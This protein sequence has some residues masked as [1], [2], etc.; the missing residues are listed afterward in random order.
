MS[1]Q[2]EIA[3]HYNSLDKQDRRSDLVFAYNEPIWES[4]YRH[5]A[6]V[7]AAEEHIKILEGRKNSEH[8]IGMLMNRV[9]YHENKIEKL[10]TD[11][12][13]D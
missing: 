2:Q 12:L 10:K 5:E 8:Q 7:N 11:L 13:N 6:F 1:L 3:G 4:I 9:G